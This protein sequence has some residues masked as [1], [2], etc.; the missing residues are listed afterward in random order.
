MKHLAN[1]IEIP[2][3][4]LAR[5]QAF[6]QGIL[7]EELQPMDLGPVKYALFP[8]ED[9][10]NCGALAQ[11]EGYEPSPQGVTVYLNGGE[12]LDAVLSRV[13]ASGGTVVMP[14]TYL[15]KEAGYIGFFF[16]TEGNKIG[17]QNL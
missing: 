8:A 10:F 9:R 12:D 14:K 2:V 5:A 6:Y 3:K 1:W 16:D 4:D 11:G 17:V 15:G 7:K 13:E